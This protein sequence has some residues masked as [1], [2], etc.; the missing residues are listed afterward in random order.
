MYA[1]AT[2]APYAT[3]AASVRAALAAQLARPV[4]FV[5]TV[6]AMYAAGARTFVEVGAGAVLTGLVG[7]V[8]GARPHRAIPLD[9]RGTHGVTALHHALARLAAAGVP[10]ALARL[11]ERYAAAHDPRTDPRPKVTLKLNGSNYGKP[12]P[13]R[14]APPRCRSPTPSAPPRAPRAPAPVHAPPLPHP[15]TKLPS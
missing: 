11:W 5:D 7:K 13:R 6:E 10:M 2:A 8:L 4:R 9:R 15:F 1:N 12:Y 14:A 3:D